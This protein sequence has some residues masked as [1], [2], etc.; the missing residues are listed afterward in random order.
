M[1]IET[2]NWDRIRALMSDKMM[3]INCPFRRLLKRI[4]KP[5]R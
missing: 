1:A 3:I 2:T 5:N 4:R